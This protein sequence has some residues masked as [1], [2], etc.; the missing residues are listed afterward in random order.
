MTAVATDREMDNPAGRARGWR[1]VGVW[2]LA[3]MLLLALVKLGWHAATT[4]WAQPHL[5]QYF[6]ID[7]N[8]YLDA[9]RD[10]LSG[11]G[12]YDA[13]PPFN[14]PPF[15]AY[16]FI[17]L[18]VLPVWLSAT[19][20]YV[21]KMV[22]LQLLLWWYL[23]RRE[24]TFRR[25]LTLTLVGGFFLSMLLEPM[26][27]DFAAGQ[28]NLLLMGLV[29]YDLCRPDDPAAPARLRGVGTGIAAAVK[30]VPALFIVHLFLTRQY[31]AATVATTTFLTTVALGFAT[32]PTT[33][34]RYWTDVLWATDRVHEHP[35]NV[36]NQSLR[37]VVARMGGLETR[38]EWALLAAVVAA[39]G[40]AIAVGLHRRG[41]TLES[42]SAVG[43]V[44]PLVTPYSWTH[45]W[46]WLLP[47]TL[48][49]FGW[50]RGSKGRLLL[51]VTL[52][53][54]IN[55][56]TYF[57][58]NLGNDRDLWSHEGSLQL[59]PLEQLLAANVVLGGLAL[60]TMGA[61]ALRG[62]RSDGPVRQAD[63]PAASRG[64]VGTTG[65]I[66]AR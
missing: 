34:W 14:Y 50:A 47:A 32:L 22:C 58:V 40:L 36:L 66:E 11:K 43:L 21:A 33:A 19:I 39:A 41:R 23:G 4:Y 24:I 20:W 51:A 38:L 12:L 25:R 46:A 42:L 10:M 64:G 52:T 15:A 61:L 65:R 57:M 16:L 2:P 45:H 17:P 1:A 27:H 31:R 13:D 29:V 3:A 9:T 7:L 28:V 60:L 26:Q 55:G 18:A 62:G 44:I 56:K 5:A 54:L 48:L 53:L 37:G 8:I 63:G 6:L 49:L 35:G 30:I 59:T